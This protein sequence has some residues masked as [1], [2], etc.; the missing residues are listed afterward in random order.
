M[1]DSD[2]QTSDIDVKNDEIIILGH[3]SGVYGV[4]GWL[5]IYSYTDPM[6]SIVSYSPWYMRPARYRGSRLSGWQPM[7]LQTGKRHAKTV[8]AQLQGCDDR[9]AAQLLI[10]YEIAIRASQLENLEGKNEFYWRELIG[11]RVVNL[12]GVT[13]GKV[14]G[15]METGANDVLV[16]Q[17]SETQP[18]DVLAED[19]RTHVQDTI[20]ADSDIAGSK[21][22]DKSKKN[23][24]IL[25]PWAFG[26][27]I[28]AVRLN[29]ALIEVDWQADWND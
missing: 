14:T 28:H 4:K 11:L 25:I 1:G 6:E 12:Q 3:V 29:D 5:K 15:F 2:F 22:L 19:D 17:A 20:P 26:H 16:I 8:V 13:L 9:N 7:L 23:P 18:V 21:Q 10:G 27:T 24:E